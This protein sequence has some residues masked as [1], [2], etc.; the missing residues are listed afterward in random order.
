QIQRAYQI[1]DLGEGGMLTVDHGIRGRPLFGE[2]DYRVGLK[3]ADMR[4]EEGVIVQ[5]ADEGLDDIAGE[6]LPDLETLMQGTDRRQGLH[7]EVEVPLA[8]GKVVDDSDFVTL[9]GQVQR[10][11]PA[12]VTISP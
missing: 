6:V 5:V 12:A 7:T 2:M 1:V 10:G 9:L 4:G 8:A 11:C 3:V